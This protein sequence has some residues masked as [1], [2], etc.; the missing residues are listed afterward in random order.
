LW[1]EMPYDKGNKHGTEK[2]YNKLGKLVGTSKFR[3]DTLIGY[4][5]C[6]DGRKGNESLDCTN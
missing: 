6:I 4:V 3:N 1:A 5:Q 2:Q